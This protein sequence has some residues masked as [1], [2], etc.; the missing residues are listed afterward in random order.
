MEREPNLRARRGVVE[1]LS[2]LARIQHS[3]LVVAQEV[4]HIT[5]ITRRRAS[6]PAKLI[7]DSTNARRDQM[8]D[9]IVGQPINGIRGATVAGPRNI[10]LE[11]QVPDIFA[12]PLTDHGSLPNLHFPF[13]YAHNRLEDGGW[14]REVTV[15][16]M[17]AMKEMAIVNM[18][19]GPGVV[20]ELHWHK[21]AEWAYI[22]AGKARL[23]VVDA[24][25]H[26]YV[27]DLDV[28]DMWLLPTGVPHSIQGL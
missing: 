25:R 18:R 23:T 7:V 11:A 22:T 2:V 16:E 6:R 17:P 14:A 1:A 24:D 12:A 15:R 4:A 26:G 27:E 10:P 3:L 5:K 9:M 8:N 28:G 13:A 20:R 21:E 19:L